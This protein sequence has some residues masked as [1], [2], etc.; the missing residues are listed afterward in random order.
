MPGGRTQFNSEW[1]DHTDTNGHRIGKW[2]EMNSTSKFEGFCMFCK[3]T[4][5]CD[6]S[7]LQQI[8]QHAT[9]K[10]HIKLTKRAR[11]PSHYCKETVGVLKYCYI[12]L[13][14]Q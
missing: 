3:K 11:N 5:R 4:I 12:R 8:L 14:I 2:C 13:C 1:L 7:G 10:S 6:N 9:G